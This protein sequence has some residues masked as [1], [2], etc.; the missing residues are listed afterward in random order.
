M[1]RLQ[2]ISMNFH[3][4]HEASG[5]VSLLKAQ[6]ISQPRALLAKI[7]ITF[8]AAQRTGTNSINRMTS[9]ASDDPMHLFFSHEQDVD[10]FKVLGLDRDDNPSPE[11]I[12]K[13]YRRLALMY[14]P[15]KAALHGNNAEKVA[16]RFQ[17][18]GFAYTVLSDSKRRKRYERTGSTSDSVWDSDEPVDWNEYFKSLWTGE[19]NAKSLSEFQSAYQGSEEERQDILQAYRDHRGSLEGIFSAVPCSNILDDEERFVEIVNAAL[20]ANELHETRAW[21]QLSS[22]TKGPKIRKTL[23]DKA[24]SEASEAEAYAKEL[25]V[26]DDLFGQRRRRSGMVSDSSQQ[27]TSESAPAHAD[28]TQRSVNEKSSS[29]ETDRSTNDPPASTAADNNNDEDV[30]VA[31]LREAM[32]AKAAKRASSFDDMI[33]RLENNHTRLASRSK[34]RRHAPS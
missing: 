29:R 4:F 16:L 13:A 10:L 18:I 27:S 19:V 15:D 20:H 5:R 31:G 2:M 7:A 14:H 12:R 34:K 3:V 11:H 23:R 6:K 22:S 32:R 24:R 30:D 21:T 28:G 26:W 9:D 17:Q 1:T 8:V 25:G 33:S